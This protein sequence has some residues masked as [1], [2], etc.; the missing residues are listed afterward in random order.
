MPKADTHNALAGELL[1]K[2]SDSTSNLTGKDFVL[3][4]TKRVS[5]ILGMEYCFVSEC[6]NEDKTRLR[7]IAFVSG[8]KVLDNV[9]YNTADSGCS[10][11]MN[12]QPYFLPKGTHELFPGA[13]GIEAYVGAP[14][15]SPVNGEILGHLAATDSHPVGDD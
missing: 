12:G 1:R 11:M 15:I 10:M 5:E 2:V 3:E 14:I 13:K 8:E 7:T 6:A 9:E 4:L